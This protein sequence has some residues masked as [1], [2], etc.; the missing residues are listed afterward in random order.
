MNYA[1]RIIIAEDEENLGKL[2]QKVLSKEGYQ[3]KY[4]SNPLEALKA[5]ETEMADIV[6]SDIKMPQL[7]GIDFLNK[8]KDIIPGIK[9]LIMTAF[10]EVDTAIEALRLGASDFLIK[11]FDLNDMVKSVNLTAQTIDNSRPEPELNSLNLPEMKQ[12]KSKS[13]K[14]Q[15]TVKLIEKIADSRSTVLI[16]GETGTG[17]ELIAQ[18]LHKLS[19]RND[20][21]FIKFNCAAIPETLIES[22]LFGYEKGAFT[23]ALH[24]KPG[25]FELADKGTLF[26]DEIGDIPITVQVKLLRTIQ[27]KE[28]ERLGGISTIKTDVRLITATNKNLEKLVS[29]Q[30]FRED[31]FYRL[32]VINID[33]PPLR[34][35]KEDLNDLCSFFLIKSSEISQQTQKELSRQVIDFFHN[36]N[37]PGNIRELENV[38]ERCVLVSSNQR[39]EL[40][41]LPERMFNQNKKNCPD[42]D[43][44]CVMDSLEASVIKKAL[45]ENNGNRTITAQK[46]GISRRSLHRKLSKFMIE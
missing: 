38:I 11:P 4:Y 20:K 27:E 33:L 25:R 13:P 9:M 30:K 18:A 8:C 26:I 12:L 17:K 40:S 19:S 6:I 28:F 7:N 1:K 16:T 41:D 10:A 34:E 24:R 42:H 3:V 32:N 5:L 29:E 2:L 43:L 35:R 39:I 23:G 22:E 44:D 14:M 45:A 31:L 36:Y 21:A 15:E 46:L 37:W